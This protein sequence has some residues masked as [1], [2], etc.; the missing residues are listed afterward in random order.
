MKFNLFNKKSIKTKSV[1]NSEIRKSVDD[2]VNAMLFHK[3]IFTTIEKNV[4]I[5]VAEI[6][7]NKGFDTSTFC[8]DDY[9][10]RRKTI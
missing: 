1:K 10:I 6:L 7:D 8:G 3:C 4:V 2:I 5:E 9:V